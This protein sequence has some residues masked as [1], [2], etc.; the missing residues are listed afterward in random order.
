VQN[1][2]VGIVRVLHERRNFPE[3]FSK[4]KREDDTKR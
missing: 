2:V 1:D 4:E 3:M